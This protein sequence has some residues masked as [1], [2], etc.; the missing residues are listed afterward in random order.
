MATPVTLVDE[1]GRY[2]GAPLTTTDRQSLSQVYRRAAAVSATPGDGVLVTGVTTAG[3]VSLTLAG[4]GTAVVSVPVGS[5]ILPFA[6]T[7]AV[8]GTAVAGT[9]QSLFFT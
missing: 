2:G 6:V 3:T 4:G 1:A 8:L 7:A 9:F 5:T